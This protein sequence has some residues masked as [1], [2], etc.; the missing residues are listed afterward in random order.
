M[1][2]ISIH[3]FLAALHFL[4]FARVLFSV[5]GMSRR[6]NR[7]IL[8]VDDNTDIHS[9]FRKILCGSKSHPSRQ[10]LDVIESQLFTDEAYKQRLT[11]GESLTGL[12]DDYELDSAFQGREALEMVR[13]AAAE[14]REY[15]LIFMDVR[16][17]PGIDGVE[18]IA[19]IWAEYPN[20]EMVIC[21]AYS[22]YSFEEILA[23]LGST[24]RL[25]FLSKP[26]DSI[27]VKQMALSLTRKWSLHKQAQLNVLALKE[28]IQE[29]KASEQK[30]YRLI[31]YDTLTQLPNRYQLAKTMETA[32][33]QA[34]ASQTRFALFFIDLSRFKDVN[35]TLGYANGDRLLQQVANRLAGLP[36]ENL[37]VF[38][39]GGDEFA[40]LLTNINGL[41]HA[42][43]VAQAICD[44][45]EPHFEL[46]GMSI[47]IQPGV[48]IV[49]FP[50]HGCST[51]MLM[52][53][54]DMALVHVKSSST[55]YRWYHEKL[56]LY[57]HQ[58]LTLLSEIRQAVH[59]NDLLLYF[60]PEVDPS[61][62]RIT[63]VESH[64]RWPHFTQGFIHQTRF[65]PLAERCGAAKLITAWILCEIPKHWSK[66]READMDLT[67]TFNLSGRDLQD[68]SFPQKVSNALSAYHMPP[69]SLKLEVSEKGVMED[70][71]QAKRLLTKL[72]DMGITLVI[73]HFGTG[74]SSL[75]HLKMLPFHQIK[76]DPSFIRNLHK[77]ANHA[78]IVQSMIHL[79]HNLGMKVLA[80]GVA[81]PE[82]FRLLADFGCDFLQGSAINVPVPAGELSLWF[83]TS[84][85]EVNR[86][87]VPQLGA[88][89]R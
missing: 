60:Q 53:H 65:M 56:N 80:D 78:K 84:K 16:M 44:T 83:E 28:K 45:F 31:H 82:T 77:E 62:Q 21:T 88:I 19:Q 14:D 27:V 35:D 58:Q 71:D 43:K 38:R 87:Q 59:A 5:V 3:Y 24:D 2:P 79:G 81:S 75:A 6:I 13:Q 86:L 51:D 7:R 72:A 76:I 48:G 64:C 4:L 1:F 74:Y 70:P 61:T 33:A 57:S 8:I 10:Q 42:A 40:V 12:E 15:A 26:F 22:D 34:R 68:A 55:P 89:T 69:Q 39:Q 29:R 73:D 11:P 37:E 85:W 17:P 67:V 47:E 20:I 49:V 66:W 63:G 54:A 52:R 32:I 9:D 30:L 46:D 41:R 25:L 18:T 50:D 36:F 23:K